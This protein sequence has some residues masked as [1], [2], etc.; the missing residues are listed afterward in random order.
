[1]SNST[2]PDEVL[3]QVKD[4]QEGID[5][6][7]SNVGV[8]EQQ[9][10]LI[11]KVISSLNDAIKA[12]NELKSKK[13]GDKIL[14]PIGGSNLILCTIK[15]PQKTFISLGSGISLQ[16]ELESSKTRNKSQIEN[17]EHSIKQLQEQHAQLTQKLNLQRQELLQIAQKYQ[18][19]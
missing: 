17:L 16:T 10:T 15:E 3:N 9:I 8:I 2:I 7:Q 6:L 18:F 12:Q 1:M 4:L 13:P 19:L 14:V 11:Y 5:Q